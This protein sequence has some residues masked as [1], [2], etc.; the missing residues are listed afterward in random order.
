MDSI[1]PNLNSGIRSHIQMPKLL[2]KRFHNQ[3]NQFFYYDV[4]KGFIGTKGTAE[5]IN[6]ELGYYSLDA[7]H[8]LSDHIEAPFGKI[9]SFIDKLDFDKGYFQLP[10]NFEYTTRSFIYSLLSRD[11]L[12]LRSFNKHSI[13]SQFM[14]DQTVHDLIALNGI[15]TAFSK[16]IFSEYS[17][18]FMVNRTKIPFV[19]PLSGLYNYKIADY[20][21]INLPISPMICICLLENAYATQITNE[22]GEI[23]MFSVDSPE[24][25]MRINTW[26]FRGQKNRNWGCVICPE[27]DE[28]DRL[29]IDTTV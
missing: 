16:N 7:E 17:L 28:L 14:P 3:K 26:A 4:K 23:S 1:K 15:S 10:S 13:F 27:R 22:H 21:I 8:Y 5:S 18:T 12:T 11:P 20:N 24:I 2:L 9:L 19:L 25:I 29:L 6:T